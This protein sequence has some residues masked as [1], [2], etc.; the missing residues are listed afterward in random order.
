MEKKEVKI[1]A[2]NDIIENVAGPVLMSMYIDGK[3]SARY[4]PSPQAPGKNEINI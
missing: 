4:C 3:R 1:N 2:R